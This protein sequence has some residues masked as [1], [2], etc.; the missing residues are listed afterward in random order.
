MDFLLFG[1]QLQDLSLI[2]IYGKSKEAGEK[3]LTQLLNRF[4]I[5]RSS[6]IYGIGRDFVDE[7]L[8]N[9]AKGGTMEVPNNQYAAPTSAFELSLIHISQNF[10]T[11]LCASAFCYIFPF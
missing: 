1:A 11:P 5:I 10:I 8:R 2:H 9:A 4:V 3:I 7:V 6:W